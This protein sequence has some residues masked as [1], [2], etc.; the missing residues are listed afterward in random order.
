M[1][2]NSL[3]LDALK[4]HLFETLE[5]VKNLSD[6]DA[7][8][9]EKVSLDQARQIVDISGKISLRHYLDGTQ[10]SPKDKRKPKEPFLSTQDGN[11]TRTRQ[12]WIRRP[13]A[14]CFAG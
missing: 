11:I 10:K 12:D 14:T 1:S 13:S 3:S 2:N 4:S 8:E 6:P 5:G 7:S 9:N